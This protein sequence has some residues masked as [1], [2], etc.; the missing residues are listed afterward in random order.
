MLA[1]LV[2]AIIILN[3]RKESRAYRLWFS[4]PALR[5]FLERSGRENASLKTEGKLLDI[6]ESKE[7][8]V[9]TVWTGKKK[10]GLLRVRLREGT[11][12]RLQ[13]GGT[14]L[15]EGEAYLASKASNP[16][17]FDL[18]EYYDS[19]GCFLMVRNADVVM[20]KKPFLPFSDA[21]YRVRLFLQKGIESGL[22]GEDAS[23]LNSFLLGI[24]DED[25][26]ALQEEFS[27]MQMLRVLL[28]SGFHL[29]LFSALLERILKK[30]MH[31]PLIRAVLLLIPCFFYTAMSGFSLSFVRAFLVLFFRYPAP[32]FRRK[33]DLLSA[34]CLSVILLLLCRPGLLF[35]PSLQYYLAALTAFG[36]LSPLVKEY[37]RKTG[38]FSGML[39]RILLFQICL[40]PLQIANSCTSSLYQPLLSVMVLPLLSMTL[41]SGFFGAAFLGAYARFGENFFTALSRKAGLGF[42]GTAHYMLRFYRFLLNA[43][44]KLPGAGIVNGYPGKARLYICFFAILFLTAVFIFLVGRR[45]KIPEEKE[46]IPGRR[47]RLLFLSFL[48]AFFFSELLFL[49][50]PEL[51]KN[52][53]RIV[54]LDVGQGDCFLISAGSHHILIDCGSS[55]MDDVGKEVLLPVLRYYGISDLDAV[56]L[57]HGDLDH[58]NGIAA[59]F[60]D[61]VIRTKQL[62][63]PE[64]AS[65]ED[66]FA[67]VLRELPEGIS[68]KTVGRGSVISGS[69]MKISCLSPEK[70][71]SLSGN[72]ASLV[73]L[74]EAAGFR[75][76]FTGDISAETEE[77]LM[78]A[79]DVDFL[80]AAHHGSEYSSSARFLKD[81]RAETVFISCGRNNPYGHPGQHTVERIRESGA[82]V[83]ISAECGA[84]C[85]YAE[86]GKTREIRR[87]L[88]EKDRFLW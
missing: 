60:S 17:V 72:E 69:Y 77:R 22:S 35:T 61:P 18:R 67:G 20:S 78:P 2:L 38:A 13:I 46:R 75:A 1:V 70:N 54:M 63:L 23:F 37:F 30:Q 36:V 19:I 33:Y 27:A 45:R 44:G 6:R 87:F 50:A 53:T 32:L 62:I 80:K 52:E 8:W 85:L 11:E 49:R 25:F 12:P 81:V 56:F 26:D 55:S 73:L 21:A 86:D 42:S 65:W 34:A 3:G 31:H 39:M 24:R 71:S 76:L 14:V 9:L 57:S 48:M 41:L 5:L 47:G 74:V 29:T 40:M 66:E 79:E 7:T 82:S 88:L 28:Q 51:K 64:T 15:V 83:C 68:G 84:V 59:L 10:E 4:P 16:G 43:F 58:T